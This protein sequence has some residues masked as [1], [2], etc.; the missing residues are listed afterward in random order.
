MKINNKASVAGIVAFISL[1]GCV[2]VPTLKNKVD[3]SFQLKA[4]LT[5]NDRTALDGLLTQTV[6][7]T[8]RKIGNKE[9]QQYRDSF[10]M[11]YIVNLRATVIGDLDNSNQL[12]VSIKQWNKKEYLEVR[13]SDGNRTLTVNVTYKFDENGNLIANAIN[14]KNTP[15]YIQDIQNE[16]GNFNRIINEATLDIKSRYID[17]LNGYNAWKTKSQ[18]LPLVG[19]SSKLDS[20]PTPK[21]IAILDSYKAYESRLIAKKSFCYQDYQ[22]EQKTLSSIKNWRACVLKNNNI[23]N[24][25]TLRVDNNGSLELVHL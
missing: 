7:H 6:K 24:S 16:A 11:Y 22:R 15:E 3:A 4:N 5:Q 13:G 18:A 9:M 10:S 17:E 12:N 23:F 20:L 1:A 2:T 25:H 21:K 14:E 19:F 8:Y